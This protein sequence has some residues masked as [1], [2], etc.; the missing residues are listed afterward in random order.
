MYSRYKIYR[1]SRDHFYHQAVYGIIPV[2]VI[3]ASVTL[4]SQSANLLPVGDEFILLQMDLGGILGIRLLQTLNIA[5]QCVDLIERENFKLQYYKPW[6]VL[7]LHVQLRIIR[8][9]HIIS[10]ICTK[11]VIIP[12]ELLSFVSKFY[13]CNSSLWRWPL[14]SEFT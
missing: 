9:I 13:R 8:S 6:V 10:T 4:S 14:A 1:V 11:I 5:T 7:L 12:F 3:E 2:G